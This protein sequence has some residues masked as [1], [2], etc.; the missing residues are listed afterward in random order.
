MKQIFLYKDKNDY[1]IWQ[2]LK[3]GNEISFEIIYKTHYELLFNY[4]LNI[5]ADRNFVEDIIQDFFV[6]IWKKHDRL[7]DVHSIKY[8]L[9]V[10][11]RRLIFKRI[12][13]ESK[14]SKNR[15]EDYLDYVLV[16]SKEQNIIDD[17]NSTE[18][19]KILSNSI[20]K[21]STRQKEIIYLKFYK[22]LSYQE[23]SVIMDINY[24]SAR[25]LLFAAIK[26]LKQ[27][28]SQNNYKNSIP[29]SI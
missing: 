3:N 14:I 27:N 23:I 9:L 18:Q 20:G 29:G 21:L 13:K 24:Q 8:Y 28:I 1:Q 10:A 12:A 26:T 19:K 7:G 2:E 16:N 11:F 4:G 25:N 17:Q 15:I 5:I 6:D 22:N